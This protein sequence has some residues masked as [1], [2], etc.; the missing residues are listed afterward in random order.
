MMRQ[1]G[2]RVR[3]ERCKGEE[4]SATVAPWRE[5]QDPLRIGKLKSLA[6]E[7]EVCLASGTCWVEYELPTGAQKRFER[8]E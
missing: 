8:W 2:E 4:V 7:A 1:V 6:L 5:Q 3:H